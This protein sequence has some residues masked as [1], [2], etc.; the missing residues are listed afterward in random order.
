MAASGRRSAMRL[1]MSAAYE[2]S[3]PSWRASS[4]AMTRLPSPR[5]TAMPT[6]ASTTIISR[7]SL[8]GALPRA[9]ALA[10]AKVSLCATMR[11]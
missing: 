9:S 5:L 4:R 2:G 1:T 3:P 10:L 11:C 7:E 6:S 8:E